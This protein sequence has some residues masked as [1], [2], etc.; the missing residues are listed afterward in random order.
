[1]TGPMDTT[2]QEGGCA[3]AGTE[4]Q[5]CESCAPKLALTPEEEAILA[6]MREIKER[7][8]PIT[9]KLKEIRQTLGEQGNGGATE[10]DAEWKTLSAKLDALRSQWREWEEKLEGA[11]E[12]KLILLGHREPKT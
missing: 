9:A 4:G 11:I 2:R 1:M 8:R 5:V 7:V 3:P 6:K 12:R 10:A